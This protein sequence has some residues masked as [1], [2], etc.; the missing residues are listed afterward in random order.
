MATEEFR[1][2]NLGTSSR[3]GEGVG[4]IDSSSLTFEVLRNREIHI[5][6]RY[7]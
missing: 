6:N 4:E 3:Y 2:G 5:V 7:K 1:R